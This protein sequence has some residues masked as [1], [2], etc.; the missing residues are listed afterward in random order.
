VH[1]GFVTSYTGN[2]Q[3]SQSAGSDGIVNFA[4]YENTSADWTA[5][6]G[7]SASAVFFDG[8][9]LAAKFVFFYQV[10]NTNPTGPAEHS[11]ST[12]RVA[13]NGGAYTSAGWL[14]DLVF[15]DAQGNVGGALNRFLGTDLPADKGDDVVD[16]VPTESGV[17]LADPAF[18][19]VVPAVDPNA[20]ERDADAGPDG[21]ASFAWNGKVTP[22]GFSSVVFLTSNTAFGGQYGRGEI[23]NGSAPSDG[24]IPTQ[25]APEPASMVV[26]GLGTALM[27][28]AVARMRRR[29][30]IV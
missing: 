2:T 12:L 21:F 19:T 1:A 7:V 3:M 8:M 18:A 17:G 6:L 14:S 25:A 20:A 22:N 13:T 10:V 26:W 28:L 11:L 5:A 29:R 16:G 27:A 30:M 23:Q 9:D 4:V 24:D 15:V